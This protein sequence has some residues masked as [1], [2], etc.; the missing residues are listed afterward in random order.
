[1]WCLGIDEKLIPL[2][3]ILVLFW[4]QS[5]DVAC[6]SF[7]IFYRSN[8]HTIEMIVNMHRRSS[9]F[10]HPSAVGTTTTSARKLSMYANMWILQCRRYLYYQSFVCFVV[11]CV[12]IVTKKN[13][14]KVRSHGFMHYTRCYISLPCGKVFNAKEA[15]P[16]RWSA[17]WK[18]LVDFFKDQSRCFQNGPT[19]TFW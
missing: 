19:N 16:Q 11:W 9:L 18:E 3:V 17:D 10:E 13:V 14:S 1:M 12:C 4:P 7:T 15:K 8:M 6:F 5:Y 2:E